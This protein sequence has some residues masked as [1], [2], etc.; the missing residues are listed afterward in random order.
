MPENCRTCRRPKDLHTEIEEAIDGKLPKGMAMIDCCLEV[1]E[2]L[3]KREGIAPSS[4]RYR[5]PGTYFICEVL[6]PGVYSC[7]R[8]FESTDIDAL[9]EISS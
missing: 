3:M 8:D 9:R 6:S 7:I 4:S 1:T 5:E 2:S